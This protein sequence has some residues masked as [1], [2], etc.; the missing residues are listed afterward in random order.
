MDETL[1]PPEGENI[2]VVSAEEA[3]RQVNAHLTQ[4]K[5]E[6][7]SVISY[8][9]KMGEAYFFENLFCLRAWLAD[10]INEQ[11]QETTTRIEEQDDLPEQRNFLAG[12]NINADGGLRDDISALFRRY[13][14][15]WEEQTEKISPNELET[16]TRKLC[17]SI[18]NLY[19]AIQSMDDTDRKN[20][21]LTY[22]KIVIDALP[23]EKFPKDE[24]PQ[25][26]QELQ[27]ISE[28][29]E[30]I[31]ISPKEWDLDDQQRNQ[32]QRLIGNLLEV[33]DEILLNPPRPQEYRIHTKVIRDK[34]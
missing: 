30:T 26:L 28:Q 23:Y 24:L 2:I 16:F 1:Q 8:T 12:V 27:G 34:I 17:A 33:S 9:D 10:R 13:D 6:Y 7:P 21:Y 25:K 22:L 15:R 5:K 29:I 14:E 32:P 3:T 18:Q 20:Q 4:L 31:P 11:I 19:D